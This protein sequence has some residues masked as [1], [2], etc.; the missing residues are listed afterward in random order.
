M[1]QVILVNENDEIIGSEEKIQAHK[2]NQLHRAF[3]VF[4]VDSEKQT[5]LL[6]KRQISKY[7]SGGLWSNSCCSHPDPNTN[8]IDTIIKRLREEL[9]IRFLDKSWLETSVFITNHIKQVGTI[10]Y[11]HDFRNLSENEIDYV[12]VLPVDSTNLEVIPNPAEVSEVE[13]I[14]FKVLVQTIEEHPKQFTAWFE[15]VFSC[16][17]QSMFNTQSPNLLMD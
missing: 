1:D 16:V 9:G 14:E 17:E 10:R 13:W 12:F 5:V 7:H 11:Q 3:S 8:L 15:K 2:N 6:Q 4:I